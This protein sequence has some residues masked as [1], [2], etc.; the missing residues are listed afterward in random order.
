LINPI[1]RD[2]EIPTLVVLNKQDLATAKKI[3]IIEEELANEM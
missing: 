3:N 2:N 1:Y